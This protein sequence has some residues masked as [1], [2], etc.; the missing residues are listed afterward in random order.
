MK[1]ILS[2]ALLFLLIFV[3]LNVCLTSL[4]Q[5]TLTVSSSSNRF[6]FQN[7]SYLGFRDPITFVTKA[8]GGSTYQEA[9]SNVTYPSFMFLQ[10]QGSNSAYGFYVSGCNVTVNSFFINDILEFVTS[11]AGTV[12]IYCGSLGTPISISSATGVYDTVHDVAAITVTSA[13]TVQV[14]WGIQPTSPPGNGGNP[15]STP[16]I[17]T[18]TPISTS[19]GSSAFQVSNINLGTITSNSTV[20]A[21]LHFTYS[22]SSI[23]LQ[24]LSFAAPFQS[25]YVSSNYNQRVFILSNV[26]N[27]GD[28][29]LTFQ[30]PANLTVQ[31]YSV[32]FSVT[33]LDAFGVS[34]TSTG[35]ISANMNGA[36]NGAWSVPWIINMVKT[37]ILFDVILAVVVLVILGVVAV[38]AP[39]KRS[40]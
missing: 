5:A 37:N 3:S 18:S 17:G 36:A 8:D 1:K 40:A 16:I 13:L 27:S 34:H 20:T 26:V 2:V 14:V 7:G 38:F 28:V 22:G 23:T 24:G 15:T 21:D 35:S 10:Q 12:D 31:N 29:T 11:G 39:K 9:S 33:A 6:G 4:T 19:S 25:W 32:G 30:V